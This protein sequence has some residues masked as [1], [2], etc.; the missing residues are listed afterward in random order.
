MKQW[1]KKILS[2]IWVSDY[3]SEAIAG[4]GPSAIREINYIESINTRYTGTEGL[5]GSRSSVKGN[6]LLEGLE[7]PAVGTN[8]S[9]G[10]IVHGNYVFNFVYN[11]RSGGYIYAYDKRDQTWYTVDTEIP[12]WS[13]DLPIGAEVRNE[14]LLYWVNGREEGG[15]V[16]GS[17]PC[18]INVEKAVNNKPRVYRLYFERSQVEDQTSTILTIGIYSP[19][20]IEEFD[21]GILAGPYDN[22]QDWCEAMADQLNTLFTVATFEG[23]GEY[24]EVTFSEVNDFYIGLALYQ[25]GGLGA[26]GTMLAV[27]YNFFIEPREEYR[28]R[29][30]YAPLCQPTFEFGYDP[31]FTQNNLAKQYLQFAVQYIYADGEHTILSPASELAFINTP[32]GVDPDT[33]FQNY[34]D[35]NFYD[36]RLNDALTF[37]DLRRVAICVRLGNEGIWRLV[38]EL[39]RQDFDILTN[40]LRFYNDGFYPA[41]S[42]DYYREDEYLPLISCGQ[43]FSQ[44]VGYLGGNLEGYD[45]LDCV[46]ASIDVNY[47]RT[48][49]CGKTGTVTGTI[50]IK[51][52]WDGSTFGNNQPIHRPNAGGY[53]KFGGIT[54]SGTPFSDSMAD[55]QQTIKLG[56]FI[57]YA[58]GTDI[59]AKSVQNVPSG[60]T[61]IGGDD[62]TFDSSSTSLRNAIRTAMNNNEV[63]STF[64]LELPEG[65]HILRIAS[66]LCSGDGVGAHDFQGGDWRSSSLPMHMSAATEIVVDVVADSSVDAGT[67]VVADLVD[68]ALLTESHAVI[69]YLIDSDVSSDRDD[70]KAGPRMERSSVEDSNATY[71][72]L[73]TPFTNGGCD[74]NGFFWYAKS[75]T[76]GFN[77][78]FQPKLG[79]G[80]IHNV[81]EN[82]Y[83]NFLSALYDATA[84]LSAT[85]V[86]CGSSG[87][88]RNVAPVCVWAKGDTAPWKVKVE[89]RLVDPSYGGVPG[90]PVVIYNCTRVGVTDGTGYY[91]ILTYRDWSYGTLKRDGWI[92]FVND[93]GCCKTYTNGQYFFFEWTSAYNFNLPYTAADWEVVINDFYNNLVW[94]RRNSIQWGIQYQDIAGRKGRVQTGKDLHVFIPFWTE[95]HGDDNPVLRFNINHEPPAWAYKWQLVRTKNQ[96]ISRFLQFIIYEAKYIRYVDTVTGDPEPVETTYDAGD[97]TEVHL[98]MRSIADYLA[99]NQGFALGFVPD[100]GDR[101]SFIKDADGI[102]YEQLFDYRM[103]GYNGDLETA[104]SPLT[105]IIP[106]DTSLPEL[107]GGELIE[108]YT[109]K[110]QVDGDNELFYECGECWDILDYGTG[111]PRH[112]G[113]TLGNDQDLDAG[114][115]ATGTITTGDVYLRSRNMV[116]IDY[117]DE[118]VTE[119]DRNVEDEYLYEDVVAS[120]QFS[121]GR[122]NYVD[123]EFKQLFLGGRVRFDQRFYSDGNKVFNGHNNFNAG[124]YVDLDASFGSITELVR[125][126]ETTELLAVMKKR[127]Q[128]IFTSKSPVYDFRG[129]QSVGKSESPLNVGTPLR[130]AVGSKHRLSIVQWDS[131]VWGFDE[132]RAEFWQFAQNDVFLLSTERGLKLETLRICEGLSQD[133]FSMVVGCFNP[134]NEAVVWGIKGVTVSGSSE[135]T[136]EAEAGVVGVADEVMAEE[137]LRGDGEGVDT[138]V[139]API[140][141]EYSVKRGGFEGS[142][143]FY[144][145]IL[146]NDGLRWYSFQGGLGHQESIGPVL[147]WYGV[148]S[149]ASITAVFADFPNTEKDWFSVREKSNAVWHCPYIYIPSDAGIPNGMTSRLTKGRFVKLEGDWFADF[150][151][152]MT[153]KTREGTEV[154]KLFNGRPLKGAVMVIEFRNADDE[155]AALREINILV[156]PSA[157]TV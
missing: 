139:L 118:E 88:F 95:S 66:N 10:S 15:K 144:P 38:K 91:S 23:C 152:D 36:P 35:I 126:G 26:V 43:A 2:G 21:A 77:T 94:K 106:F 67:F 73:D 87:D 145:E 29:V 7:L 76:I 75:A 100:V 59:W 127:I 107:V 151:R 111:S 13:P 138:E 85:T 39:E 101:V 74:H 18:K 47:E 136:A 121:I 89:G 8:T 33:A 134:I 83:T 81:G 37:S 69:G 27:P 135:A 137:T 20:F 6:V 46:D 99:R 133:E 5:M 34:I 30:K 54:P 149:Y 72:G 98:N 53:V 61:T 125:I 150:L 143:L 60:V 157:E 32:C 52:I 1:L 155:I 31:E 148:K 84:L 154:E 22:L 123:K 142:F 109:P 86:S 115:P 19:D 24:I 90:V 28:S 78:S 141:I 132:A 97:A 120:R 146:S 112:G 96:L 57:V 16:Y 25:Y 131:I 41:V 65:R 49:E 12:G 147:T 55:H 63:Y 116:I 119:Y 114:T 113:G 4:G 103:S 108:V 3:D 92:V 156:S 82:F 50:R 11:S 68:T 130:R 105:Y 64:E 117:D 93:S 44:N 56:G 42:T 17:Y 40:K 58:V 48:V 51:N 128:P 70:L 79:G 140:T 124:D 80:G 104:S 129:D 102:L 62:G 110:K 122:S 9:V 153:D 45:N 14:K 71:Y